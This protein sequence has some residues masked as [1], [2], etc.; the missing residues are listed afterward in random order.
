MSEL[1]GLSDDE[2]VTRVCSGELPPHSLEDKLGDCERAVRVRRE[3]VERENQFD[4]STLPY[5]GF[6]Y[7]S[8]LGACAEMVIGYVP[9]PVGVAGPLLMNGS[10]FQVPMATVEGTLIASTRRGCKAIT[11]SGGASAAVLQHAMTRAPVLL[12]PSAMRAAAFKKWVEEPSNLVILKEHFDSTSRFARLISVRVTVAGKHAYARFSCAT[13]DAMG[14]NMV[15]K[16]VSAA[17]DHVQAN[18]FEDMQLLGLSGNMCCD[19]KPSAINWIE[20]RGCSVVAEATIRKDVV[21]KV[22]LVLPPALGS[23]L[24]VL[25]LACPLTP[26]IVV[27]WFSR[28]SK[29]LSRRQSS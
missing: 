27:H 22:M 5:K 10:S 29:Q 16:G 11:E 12:F 1:T 3:W 6:D 23:S 8:V 19:K 20:G 2:L 26:C 7:A 9:L 4:A 14:M 28:S 21:Q 17:I 15:S 18:H 25:L 24:V 13:G